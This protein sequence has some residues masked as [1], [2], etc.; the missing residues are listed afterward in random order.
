MSIFKIFIENEVNL[1]T[2]EIESLGYHRYDYKTYLNNT[3][4]QFELINNLDK[5]FEQLNVL[6]SV[7]IVDCSFFNSNFIQQIINLTK[8]FK[9]KSLILNRSSKIETLQQLLQ[10]F[11]NN[12]ENF[13]VR[14]LLIE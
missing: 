2:L 3:R 7:H 6:E 9:L 5:V 1:H 11:G 14:F 4:F 8:P 13:A 10:K 12:L